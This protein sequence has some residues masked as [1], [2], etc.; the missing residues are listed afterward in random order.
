MEQNIK[1]G[2]ELIE[3]FSKRLKLLRKEE[4]YTLD[5]LSDILLEKYDLKL[6]KS[7]LSNYERGV[8]TP[9][10]F[11][12]SAFADIYNV[13]IDWLLGKTDVRNAKLL[14]TCIFD[15]EGKEHDVQIAVDKDSDLANMPVG[16]V[17]NLIRQIKNL[18]INFDNV[19]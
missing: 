11:A 15:K 14:Q 18:G 17:I 19:K 13:S 3:E 7:N 16:D 4:R 12:L 10:I 1:I 8:K 5:E 2:E 9:Y 6:S